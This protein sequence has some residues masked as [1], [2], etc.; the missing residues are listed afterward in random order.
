MIA[1]YYR[2]M[3]KITA[4]FLAA[5]LC[6]SLA[7][8]KAPAAPSQKEAV[9]EAAATEADASKAEETTTAATE[10][11]TTE[12]ATVEASAAEPSAETEIASSEAETE[13][14][15]LSDDEKASGIC[16]DG[17]ELIVSE[18]GDTLTVRLD[19]NATTGYFWSYTIWDENSL[20]LSGEDYKEKPH[21][22]GMVGVGGVWEAE[23]KV[24]GDSEGSNC[25][26]FYYS[27][28]AMDVPVYVVD[29]YE[30]EGKLTVTGEHV[31][32]LGMYE[33]EDGEFK[34]VNLEFANMFEENELSFYALADVLSPLV[35]TNEE[36]AEITLGDTF[37]GFIY[38]APAEITVQFLEPM[39]DNISYR[40]TD[41]E[42]L[43]YNDH[44]SG[45]V[46]ESFDDDD[47][48]YNLDKTIKVHFTNETHIEDQMEEI[49]KTGNSGTIYDKMRSYQNVQASLT[50]KDREAESIKIFYHP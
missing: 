49:L 8:C 29:V 31:S 14:A 17:H 40:I 39:N 26:N 46:I 9:T 4:V 2:F 37:T 50:V 28:G 48:M 45:W 1:R 27:R 19:A 21:A 30:R 13:A 38:G 33:F 43:T 15:E 3:K 23:F 18:S 36:A 11:V 42:Y 6:F 44:L 10:A 35:F 12:A 16:P 5:A 41:N 24:T 47:L 7:A 20:A 22:D 25:V 34:T 32:E